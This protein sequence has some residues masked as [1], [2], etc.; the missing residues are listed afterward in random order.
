MD[1][2][3]YE[4]HEVQYFSE[5]I[6]ACH[7]VCVPGD[8]LPPSSRECCGGWSLGQDPGSSWPV[9]SSVSWR[10]SPPAS[11]RE[12]SRTGQLPAHGHEQ[13]VCKGPGEGEDTEC[14]ICTCDGRYII[15]VHVP[16]DGLL[17]CTVLPAKR[18]HFWKFWF[19]KLQ[20]VFHTQIT[21]KP[22]EN[23]FGLDFQKKK[24]SH[25]NSYM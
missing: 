16:W 22:P 3:I 17:G 14:R 25:I 23:P 19:S 7:V 11:C 15:V 5:Q 8:P 2:T 18:V 21:I 12:P 9:P 4:W 6:L 13:P 20:P 10:S 1:T 24:F